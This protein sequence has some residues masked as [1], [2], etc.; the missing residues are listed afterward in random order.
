MDSRTGEYPQSTFIWSVR[1][2]SVCNQE[3]IGNVILSC[4]IK[5]TDMFEQ[6]PWILVKKNKCP[7][8]MKIKK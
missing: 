2:F 7:I 1:Y 8:I 4:S 3:N 6:Q 5:E